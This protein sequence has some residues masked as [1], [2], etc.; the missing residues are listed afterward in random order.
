VVV[1]AAAPALMHHAERAELLVVGKRGLGDRGLAGSV[2]LAMAA[3]APCPVVVV[4]AG[5]AHGSAAAA[6]R[7]V[8]LSDDSEP[9]AAATRFAFE[10]AA[11]RRIGLT[12]IQAW[13]PPFSGYTRL[14]IGLPQL[15]E[16]Q[17]STLLE[18]L[19][20]DRDRFPEVE[21]ELKLV[22]GKHHHRGQAL[23]TESAHATLVV[24]GFH[25]HGHFG[26]LHA[27]A[28]CQSLLAHAHCPVAVVKAVRPTAAS[29]LLRADVQSGA[30]GPEPTVRAE[31]EPRHGDGVVAMEGTGQSM[32]RP[33]RASW[34]GEVA[35]VRSWL[36]T[37]Q[38]GGGI[39]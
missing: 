28:V 14:V 36:S 27:D 23:I 37:N 15:G 24:I 30:M 7:I 13:T 16:E 21:L 11:R 38:Q 26:G 3:R 9:S 20:S 1:G 10:A 2:G 22:R 12:V 31:V 18:T 6:G 5:Q 17:R 39:R 19:A 4:P 32:P 25:G 8:V 35:A 34:S 29:V 33:M